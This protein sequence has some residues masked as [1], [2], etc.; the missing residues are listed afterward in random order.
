MQDKIALGILNGYYGGLL[1]AHQ[2]EVMRLYFDCDMSLAEV[3]EVCGITRQG[4][5]EV[6]VNSSAKLVEYENKLGLVGK[7]KGIASQLDKTL[8]K[9]NDADMKKEL[10]TLLESIKEI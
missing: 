1:T 3:S 2:Q 8:T 9:V 7:I 4:V 10:Q 6:V 5:R